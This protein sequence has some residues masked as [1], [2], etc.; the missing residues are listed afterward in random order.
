MFLLLQIKSFYI[1]TGMHLKTGLYILLCSLILTGMASCLGGSD[2]VEYITST[3][4]Q[5]ISFSISHDSV[6]ALAKT[7]FSIDQQKNEIYNYDSLPYL[8]KVYPKAVITFTMGSGV[9]DY[10]LMA[11]VEGDTVWVASADSLD[12]SDALLGGMRLKTFA[13]DGITTKEYGFRINIHQIDPDSVR[14]ARW[15]SDLDFLDYEEKKTV[16]FGSNYYTFVKKPLPATTGY[17]GVIS[18]YKSADMNHWERLPDLSELPS[19]TNV[20]DI[21][22]SQQG[23]YAHAAGELYVAYEDALTGITPWQKI[24]TENPVVSVLGYLKPTTNQKD[25]VR[26][27]GLALIVRRDDADVFAFTETLHKDDFQYGT[28]VPDDFPVSG[29]SVINNNSLVWEKITLV[30]GKSQS[31]EILNTVW[32]TEDGYHWAN[33]SFDPQGNLPVIEGGNAFSYAGEI[34]F[35]SGR[36]ENGEYNKEIYSSQDGGLVWKTKET[37]THAPKE[38]SLRKEASVVVDEQ[39]IY[40][41]IVGGQNQSFL[42]DIWKA[43]LNS[44]IFEE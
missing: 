17:N 14:Y 15:A 25:V 37:K 2:D 41:Y 10:M 23:L 12:I 27:G 22:V 20:R 31:G 19:E 42:T 34:Y 29:F 6:P 11:V 32:A 40:F 33:L 39:G 13:P 26:K 18:L 30:A 28:T 43:A 36:L 3:D 4:A 44:R 35:L 24:E 1:I 21:Q 9:A 38:F 7:S 16:L 5:I 8:T